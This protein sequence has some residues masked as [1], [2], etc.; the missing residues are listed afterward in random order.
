MIPPTIGETRDVMLKLSF[1]GESDTVTVSSCSGKKI[2]YKTI[3]EKDADPMERTGT[4]IISTESQEILVPISLED[5]DDIAI[6]QER[7]DT[8]KKEN[9]PEEVKEV[10]EELYNILSTAVNGSLDYEKCNAF[11]AEIITQMNEEALSAY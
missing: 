10:E 8:L 5:A 7:I 1:A 3:F 9:R 11:R 4:L 6:I 2:G